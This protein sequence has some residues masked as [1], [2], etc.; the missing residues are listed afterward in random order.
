LIGSSGLVGFYVTRFGEASDAKDAEK[1]V[2]QIL[3]ADPKL[4]QPLGHTPSGKAQIVFE[5][6]E[7]VEIIGEIPSSQPG[8]V[9]FA[10]EE[11]E[12]E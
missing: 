4:A 10:M 3:R 2:L 11:E 7:E 1:S 8:I 5:E 12:D 6:I 9:F